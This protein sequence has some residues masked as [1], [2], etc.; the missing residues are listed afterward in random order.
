MIIIMYFVAIFYRKISA[1]ESHSE[2]NK[3]ILD[4]VQLQLL[5]N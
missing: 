2:K 5:N 1:L 4:K 3:K